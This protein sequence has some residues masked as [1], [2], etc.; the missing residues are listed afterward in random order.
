MNRHNFMHICFGFALLLYLSIGI[1]P[2]RLNLIQERVGHYYDDLMVSQ[3]FLLRKAIDKFPKMPNMPEDVKLDYDETLAKNLW[4]SFRPI[5][6]LEL[7]LKI[8][9]KRRKLDKIYNQKLINTMLLIAA[10][11]RDINKMPESASYYEKIKKLDE[12]NLPANDPR[13]TRDQINLAMT[14]YL[15]GDSERD[16]A[17]RSKYF[18]SCLEHFNH[19]QILWHAQKNASIATLANLFFLKYLACRELG[20]KVASQQAYGE[21]K[22]LNKRLARTVLLPRT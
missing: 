17:K 3:E 14:D 1:M 22:Y 10:V 18:K 8:E 20:D 9:R 12:I 6:A 13:L 7:L 16:T 11:Y 5:Q 15:M 4:A 19:A 21:M 2:R